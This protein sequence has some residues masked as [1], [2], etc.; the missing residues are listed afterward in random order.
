MLLYELCFTQQK[1]KKKSLR[2]AKARLRDDIGLLKLHKRRKTTD[3]SKQL[4]LIKSISK[5][6][7][8]LT[9][10]GQKV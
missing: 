6:L 8:N 1:C 4:P 10:F 5:K 3:G 2:E 7:I 9:P